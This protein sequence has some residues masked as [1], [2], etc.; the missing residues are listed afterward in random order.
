MGSPVVTAEAT[1]CGF[2]IMY[3]D[4]DH[5]VQ[6]IKINLAAYKKGDKLPQ[7]YDAP[8]SGEVL[9]VGDFLLNDVSDNQIFDKGWINVLLIAETG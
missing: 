1:I 3:S 5:N 8:P 7:G 9:V 4:D 6:E 2:D